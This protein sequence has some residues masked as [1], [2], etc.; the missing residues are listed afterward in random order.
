[1][2]LFME[3][4]KAI[5][6]K[7]TRVVKVFEREDRYSLPPDEYAFVEFYCDEE[8]CDCRRVMISVFAQKPAK[9]LATISLGFDSEEDDA[10]PYL[11]PLTTQSEYSQGLLNLFVDVINADPYYLARLQRHYVKF[12]EKIDGKNMRENLSKHP[13][14][15]IERRISRHFCHFQNRALLRQNPPLRIGPKGTKSTLPLR[16]RQKIQEMLP[17]FSQGRK[18]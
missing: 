6:E 13:A 8:D 7:E 14:R 2:L 18:R 12:K 1:M 17:D 5:G 4:F 16:L 9:F 10:G 3:K 11:E 15:L